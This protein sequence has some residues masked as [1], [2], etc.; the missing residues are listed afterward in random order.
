MENQQE[1]VLK[2]SR[3]VIQSEA[4]R[5]FSH[6]QELTLMLP[7]F[8]KLLAKFLGKPVRT[9]PEKALNDFSLLPEIHQT[10]AIRVLKIQQELLQ[11]AVASGLDAYN[12]LGML[13]MAMDKLGLL[14]DDNLL[15][16]VDQTDVIEI[17]DPNQI[18]V[19]R[20][21]SCFAFCNYSLA[22]LVTYPWF[23][24][25]ERP[26][27]VQHKLVEVGTPIYMDG[28]GFQSLESWEPYTL[29]ETLTE[30]K[31][32]FLMQE[33]FLARMISRLT[34]ETYLLS[35]KRVSELEASN[36]R[37]LAFLGDH[38]SGPSLKLLS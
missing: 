14:V 17:L 33:K 30:E 22:E 28:P 4:P 8:E 15:D 26:A 6:Q 2:N 11:Q 32:A 18:Q 21:F 24:L 36:E 27:W 3:P 29:R 20:S 19:Y 12:E 38:R 1:L 16:R 9:S 7:H 37:N 35:V 5:L 34:R 13:R 10:Q 31:A 25:Y 23:M